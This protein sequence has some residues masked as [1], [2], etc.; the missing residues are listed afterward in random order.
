MRTIFPLIHE[1]ATTHTLMRVCARPLLR[2]ALSSAAS[3]PAPAVRAPPAFSFSGAGFLSA[4]HLG[5]AHGLEQTGAIGPDSRVA[6][7]SGGAVIAL[8]VAAKEVSVLEMHEELKMLAAHCREDGTLWKLETYLRAAFDHKFRDVA[9]AP[10]NER[11][12]IAALR[13]WPDPEL[14]LWDRFDSVAALGDVVIASCFIP[15]YL[16][17]RGATKIGGELFVDAGPLQLVP[18]LPGYTKV[19]AFHASVLRRPDYEI[20]PSIVPN[21]PYSFLHL[22]R[23]ALSPPPVAML[24]ELFQL[25][26]QSAFLWAEKHQ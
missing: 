2:R 26:K 10:L 12:T 15:F 14:V 9:L 25:G 18:E 6:G 20:S 8:A 5:V 3:A 1:F 19:C 7:A 21:F 4:Y 23:A 16:A 11:L 17:R 24:D 22:A 13:V